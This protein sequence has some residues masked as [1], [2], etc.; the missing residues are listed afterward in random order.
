MS[1]VSLVL[2]LEQGNGLLNL[3]T[4]ILTPKSLGRYPIYE[5]K[6]SKMVIRRVTENFGVYYP[7]CRAMPEY[8]R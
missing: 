4:V 5:T 7:R 8:Q 6:G 2:A 3:Q 1:N